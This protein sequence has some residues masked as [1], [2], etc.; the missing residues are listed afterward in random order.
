VLD[1]RVRRGIHLTL[2]LAPGLGL[3]AWV[4]YAPAL[5]DGFRKS[6]RQLLKWNDELPFVKFALADD[7][8]IVLSAEL[9]L[10]GLDRDALGRAVARL[11][12]VC[13]LLAE[14]SARWLA[15][16][17]GVPPVT[18]PGTPR[19]HPVIDRYAADIAELMESLGG[20]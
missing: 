20:S 4:H 14:P 10:A 9:P 16:P 3:V 7:E 6:Y 18:P 13:D 19:H 15:G 1:G 11:V 5:A 8:R 17:G 12:A 2:I